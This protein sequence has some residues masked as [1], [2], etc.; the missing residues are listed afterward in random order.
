[1]APKPSIVTLPGLPLPYPTLIEFLTTRFPH[2]P[3]A[4]WRN[5]LTSGKVT[6]RDGNPI[7]PNTPYQPHMQLRYYREISHEPVIPFQETLLYQDDHLIVACKPHF[8]PVT[9]GGPYVNQCLLYRLIRHTGIQTLTPIHRL[10]KDTAGVILFSANPQTRGAY[11]T[12]FDTGQVRKTYEAVALDPTHPETP[13]ITV[14]GRIESGSPF[15]RMQETDGPINAETDFHL[16]DT[17]ERQARFSVT[18][19]TGKKHQIRLHMCRIAQGIVNDR[20]YPILQP[21]TPLDLEKPLKLIS[22]R[23][24]FIDPL[25]KKPREFTSPRPLPWS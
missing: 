8:L 23:I 10:D 17:F 6:D 7:T 4:V 14:R 21:E 16:T 18:P 12:L 2:V 11:Q 22:R 20:F 25:S 3:E 19:V 13:Q 9:P 24:S 5:R 15:F 1:M